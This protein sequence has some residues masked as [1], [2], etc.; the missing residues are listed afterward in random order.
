MDQAAGI[1]PHPCTL[2]AL[3]PRRG[4]GRSTACSS[5]NR[6]LP[7]GVALSQNSRRNRSYADAVGEVP[8]AA[9]HQRLVHR[10]LE[11][12]VAL[13][14]VAVLVRLRGLDLLLS[15]RSDPSTPDTA[16]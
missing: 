7:A 13:F 6:A 10:L 4:S 12:V 15:G 5:A 1:D 9:Q 8:A 2:V 14:H 3:Q 11:A 16:A